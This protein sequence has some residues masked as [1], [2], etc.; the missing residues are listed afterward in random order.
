MIRIPKPENQLLNATASF[1]SLSP[2]DPAVLQAARSIYQRDY[3]THSD[4]TQQPIGVAID[5]DNLHGKLIFAARPILLPNECF[6]PLNQLRSRE[7]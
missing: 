4:G 5:R 1:K 2:L 7:D 3:K 6:V